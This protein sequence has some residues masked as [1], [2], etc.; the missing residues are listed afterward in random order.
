LLLNISRFLDV[1]VNNFAVILQIEA[2]IVTV[3]AAALRDIPPPMT[4]ND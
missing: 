4:F 2:R 3:E 1:N